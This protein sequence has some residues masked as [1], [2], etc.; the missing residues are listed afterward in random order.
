MNM[1]K[2]MTS[3][4]VRRFRIEVMNAGLRLHEDVLDGLLDNPATFVELV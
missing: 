3:K 2:G 1:I 4:A